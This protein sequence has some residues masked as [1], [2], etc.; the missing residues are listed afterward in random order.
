MTNDNEEKELLEKVGRLYNTVTEDNLK[1]ASKE[2]VIE[3]L[4]MVDDLKAML[5]STI[6]EEDLK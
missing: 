4:K 1:K 6:E 3:Y 5:I 2:E